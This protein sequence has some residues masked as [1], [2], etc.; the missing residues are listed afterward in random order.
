MS[1][2]YNSITGDVCHGSQGQKHW[3]KFLPILTHFAG[4]FILTFI[5][6]M[7]SLWFVSSACKKTETFQSVPHKGLQRS[8]L[9]LCTPISELTSLCGA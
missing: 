1:T 3:N 7:Q 8:V 2:S 5:S 6:K 9:S 4:I